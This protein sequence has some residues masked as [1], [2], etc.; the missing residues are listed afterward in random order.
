MKRET[1][2][3]FELGQTD[4]VVDDNSAIG[5]K[6]IIGFNKAIRSPVPFQE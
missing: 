1:L 2:P 4:H 5:G 6:C 3:L